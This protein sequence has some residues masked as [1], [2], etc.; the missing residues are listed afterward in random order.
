TLLSALATM[1]LVR[2]VLHG[3]LK[4]AYICALWLTLA[5]ATKMT[6]WIMIAGYVAVMVYELRQPLKTW[7]LHAAGITLVS[8]IAPIWWMGRNVV[9]FGNPFYIGLGDMAATLPDVTLAQFLETQ[10][11]FYFMLVHF[12]ALFGFSGYCQTPE[13]THLC[14]GT[15]I[16]HINNE[17]F[18]YFIL[19][20]CLMSLAAVVFTVR[21]GWRLTRSKSATRSSQSVQEWAAQTIRQPQVR[22]A[23]MLV[24]YGTGIALFSV[25]W[26]HV[27]QEPGVVSGQLL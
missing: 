14:I 9:N 12:Y 6:A 5:G 19:V 1:Y 10:P 22:R 25:A 17:P 24:L 8:L 4:D 26:L 7:F 15:Q 3:R 18:F 21:Q 27:H 13:L 16:T 23:L 11:F 20:L 2:F